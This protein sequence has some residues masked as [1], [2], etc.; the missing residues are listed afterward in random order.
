ML[1]RTPEFDEIEIDA[2]ARVA[3]VGAGVRWGR[4]LEALAGTGLVALAGSS[5]VVNA[6]AFTIGGGHS[7]FS[8]AHGTRLPGR[9]APCSC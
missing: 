2:A 5:P 9:C 4:V 8:R 3:R 7:W 1:V 6:T